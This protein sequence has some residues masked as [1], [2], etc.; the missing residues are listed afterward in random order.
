VSKYAQAEREQEKQAGSI[1]RSP[2]SLGRSSHK[3][4]T[5]GKFPSKKLS[6]LTRGA[7]LSKERCWEGVDPR[8][9]RRLRLPPASQRAA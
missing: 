7:R 4:L 3:P 5:D 6:A 8:S 1:A 2:L 9:G